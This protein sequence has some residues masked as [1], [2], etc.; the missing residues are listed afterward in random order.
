MPTTTTTTTSTDL[1]AGT[2]IADP[3]HSQVE[4]VIRHLGLSKVRGRFNQFTATVAI[5]DELSLSSVEATVELSSV[6]T[7]NEDRDR[8]LRSTEF[9]DTDQQSQITF[10]STAIT[11][12]APDYRPHGDLIINA[13]TKPVELVLEFGGVAI[14]AYGVTRAG[15]SAETEIS[16][17]DFGGD[18]N[19]PLPAGGLLLADKVKIELDIQII[20]A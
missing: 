18:F 3:A 13:T 7:N 10:T 17:T 11:G 19:I 16:R 12:T 1:A 4:F 15:F 9:F 6:D 20:P 2:C 5:D 14:D 8:H